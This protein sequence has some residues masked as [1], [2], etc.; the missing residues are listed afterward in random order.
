MDRRGR[1][2]DRSP[3]RCRPHPLTRCD[4][5]PARR[6]AA[7]SVIQPTAGAGCLPGRRGSIRVA[8]N[9]LGL[10]TQFHSVRTGRVAIL[11]LLPFLFS[12]VRQRRGERIP[13]IVQCADPCM[14][15]AVPGKLGDADHLEAGQAGLQVN[16]LAAICRGGRPARRRP[17]T[18]SASE[19]DASRS[20]ASARYSGA[21][22]TT[23]RTTPPGSASAIDYTLSY[24]P[25]AC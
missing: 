15:S 12:G 24:L 19:L 10:E 9:R 23:V 5:G 20:A 4:A 3:A 16:W 25:F 7:P 1:A 6:A 8:E 21:P 22:R 13:G 14:D 11:R 18:C 17:G 2:L